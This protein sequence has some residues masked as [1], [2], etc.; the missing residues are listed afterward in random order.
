M[1]NNQIIESL[2]CP[3]NPGKVYSTKK[4]F[5]VHKQSARHRA[6][7]FADNNKS[8]QMKNTHLEN[9]IISLNLEIG[10]LEEQAKNYKKLCE[11]LEIEKE[12]LGLEIINKDIEVQK[13][14]DTTCKL[15]S[16]NKVLHE[17][18]TKI[19]KITNEIIN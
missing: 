7:D 17:N 6:H 2:T 15:D 16:E 11:E 4:T 19:K 12:S 9:R 13:Y 5:N 14:K 3:C 18:L 8:N 1:S 10:Q